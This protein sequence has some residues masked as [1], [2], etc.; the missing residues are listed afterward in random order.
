MGPQDSPSTIDNHLW[1]SLVWTNF[2]PGFSD[3][4]AWSLDT[5]GPLYRELFHALFPLTKNLFKA[6]ESKQSK[7][8][9]DV[10]GLG[11]CFCR[12]S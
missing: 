11:A 1:F 2:N 6:K 12:S 8:T 3:D 4:G 9:G 10:H 5:S 7:N